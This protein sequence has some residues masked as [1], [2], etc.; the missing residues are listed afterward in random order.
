MICQKCVKSTAREPISQPL[1]PFEYPYSRTDGPEMVC[2]LITRF[3]A[4]EYTVTIRR[5]KQ[6]RV[7]RRQLYSVR[8]DQSIKQREPGLY[9]REAQEFV[10]IL[11]TQH[12][13]LFQR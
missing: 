10:H 9:S 11:E 1:L 6:I 2:F 4:K 13:T 12:E 8:G 3:T 5:F 7:L